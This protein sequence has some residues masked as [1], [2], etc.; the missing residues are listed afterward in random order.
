MIFW[1]VQASITKDGKTIQIPT[2]Y[3][4]SDIQGITSEEVCKKVAK[5]TVDPFGDAD[6]VSINCDK[7]QFSIKETG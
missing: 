3:L 7:W 5:D 1:I 4:N 2:F 6:E